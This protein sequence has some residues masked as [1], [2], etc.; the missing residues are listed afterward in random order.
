MAAAPPVAKNGSGRRFM[1]RKWLP[2]RHGF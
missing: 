2:L 1:R